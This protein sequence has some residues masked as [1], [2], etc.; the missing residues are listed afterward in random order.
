MKTWGRSADIYL[1]IRWRWAIS[2]TP[3]RF[4]LEERAPRTHWTGGLVGHRDAVNAVKRKISYFT[5]N[6]RAL[7]WSLPWARSIQSI[8]SHPVSLRSSLIQ[9]TYLRLGLPSGLFPSGFPTNISY[10]FL[11]SPFMLHTLPVS[12]SLTSSSCLAR[13]TS[14]EAP[15]YAVSSNLPSLHL[16]CEFS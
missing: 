12:S 11:F 9:S 6:R 3:R 8:P 15:R 5:R 14:Y 2:I 10:A 16:S 7:H 13:S 1:G 4:T